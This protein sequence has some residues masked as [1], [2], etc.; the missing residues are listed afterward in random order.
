MKLGLWVKFQPRVL[1][2]MVIVEQIFTYCSMNYMNRIFDITRTMAERHM[3]I[4]WLIAIH[5]G[6]TLH[7]LRYTHRG[8]SE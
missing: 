1:E 6:E 8:V 7:E 2:Y 4:N 3:E 5:K